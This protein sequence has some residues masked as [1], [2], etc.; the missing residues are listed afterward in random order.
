M[1]TSSS[2]NSILHSGGCLSSFGKN[3]VP[4]LQFSL[5]QSFHLLETDKV[6]QSVD[7]NCNSFIAGDLSHICRNG[8]ES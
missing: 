8:R 5:D 7:V 3:R 6:D 1:E 2:I 4:S